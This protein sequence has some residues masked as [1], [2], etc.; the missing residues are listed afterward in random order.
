MT[1]QKDTHKQ[2]LLPKVPWEGSGWMSSAKHR[3]I[4][5]PDQSTGKSH[6]PTVLRPLIQV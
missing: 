5:Q 1:P 6:G 3:L 4:K 2:Q